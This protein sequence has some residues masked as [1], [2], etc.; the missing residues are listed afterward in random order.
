MTEHGSDEPF[1]GSCEGEMHIGFS[2]RRMLLLGLIPVPFC[3]F[4][5]LSIVSSCEG[6]SDTDLVAISG[7]GVP[8]D[9]CFFRDGRFHGCADCDLGLPTNRRFPGGCLCAKEYRG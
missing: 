7:G 5:L 1:A 8:L 3:D 6:G 2:E 4:E 9:G